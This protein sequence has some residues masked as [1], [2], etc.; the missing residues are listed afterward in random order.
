VPKADIRVA[1]DLF[2]YLLGTLLKQRRHVEPKNLGD[3]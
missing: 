1:P 3:L 2:D